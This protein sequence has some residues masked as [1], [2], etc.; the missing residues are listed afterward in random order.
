MTSAVLSRPDAEKVL[1][2]NGHEVHK[3][4]GIGLDAPLVEAIGHF[5]DFLLEWGFLPADF[6]LDAWV[7]HAPL[8]ALHAQAAEPAALA[9]A[10]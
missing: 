8:R 9:A 10:A 4:L 5:K 3:H 1:A 2:S 6:D 7:D